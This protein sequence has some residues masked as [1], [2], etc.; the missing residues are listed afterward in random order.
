M[1]YFSEIKIDWSPFVTC[2]DGVKAPY[3]RG[4]STSEGLGDRLRFV[5]FAEKQAAH[6][7]STAA[8]V[9]PDIS[10]GARRIWKKLAEEEQKHL[11]WLLWRMNELNISVADRPVSLALWKS[12]DRCES[13]KNFAQ[14]M[15]SSEEHGRVAGEKFY[16]T[17]LKIDP[18]SAKVF[19][20]IALEEQE[21]IRLA[22]AVVS[23]DFQ[24]PEDFDINIS[25]IPLNAYE[26]L[27]KS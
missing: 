27:T 17:L 5:A 18:V 9:F 26:V 11:Q 13:A 25:G 22:Q 14:Y 10:V 23:L 8:D 16:E 1:G 2:A 20:Q 21:H 3:P 6:A 15:A 7:F 4:L 24:V 19:Q 12:F